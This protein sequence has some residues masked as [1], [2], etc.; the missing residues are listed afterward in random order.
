MFLFT[1][2]NRIIKAIGFIFLF[3][4]SVILLSDCEEES[5]RPRSYPRVNTLPVSNIT[6]NGATFNAEISSLGAEAITEHGFVWGVTINPTINND[7]ILLGPIETKGSYSAEVLTT[8]SKG[9]K[10]T[11]KP[12]V[13]TVDHIVYGAPVTFESLGSKA[14]EIYGFDPDSAGWMDT[15]KIVGK[16][17]SWVT[18]SNKVLFNKVECPTMI[19]TDTTLFVRINPNMSDYK[20]KIS[21]DLAG[22]IVI[23]DKKDFSLILPRI[24]GIS[25]SQA[26][27]GDT[28]VV[29]GQNF[30]NRYY[31][32]NISGTISGFNIKIIDKKRDS[33]LIVVP[34][35]LV[36]VLNPIKIKINNLNITASEQLTL[37]SPYI[38]GIKPK[39]GTWGTIVTLLGKFHPTASRNAIKIGGYSVT[40]LSNSKDSIKVAAPPYL[41]VRNNLVVN[42]S[43]PF[44]LVSPDTF[45]IAG[46]YIESITPLTGVSNSLI[47]I[48]GKYLKDYN[49][50]TS[51]KFGTQTATIAGRSDSQIQCYVPASLVNGPVNITVTVL[52]QTSVYK[53]PYIVDNPVITRVYPLNGTFN[54]EITIEGEKLLI[55][56]FNPDVY[57]SSSSG[58][59]FATM[60]SSSQNKI[61]VKVPSGIDS[62]PSKL[63][64]YYMSNSLAVYSSDKFTLSPPEITSVPSAVLIPGQDITINGN[65]F[66][67]GTTGNQVFWGKYPLTVTSSAT[68]QIVATV[69]AN[70]P[71]GF[72]KIS[73]I[74]GGYKREYPV[75]FESKSAWSEIPI[76]SSL[77]WNSKIW[78][79]GKGIAFTIGGLSY[80]IDPIGN[81]SS[82]NP[83]TKEFVNLGL[84]NE[85]VNTQGFATTLMNDTL[86]AVGFNYTLLI[87][88][89]RYDVGSNLWVYIGPCP[90]NRSNGVAFSLNG[91]V[92][93]GLG[94]IADN[95]I[96]EKYL[97]AFDQTTKKWILKKDIAL[98]SYKMPVAYFTYNNKGYVL[99]IDNIFCEY[100]PDTDVWTKLASFPGPGYTTYDR[101]SFI[102]NSKFYV[103]MGKSDYP[104]TQS[105]DFWYY[106][107]VT[108]VW[109][110]S[111][112]APTSGRYNSIGFVANNKVYIG[113]G[114][115]NTTP[116]RDFYEFDPNYPLK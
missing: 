33:L 9:I 55:T 58:E 41:S 2:I 114:L 45:K 99:F 75:L 19:S 110:K 22:N 91:K 35:E 48:K 30:T 105:N 101:T 83:V 17:F 89:Y 100:N 65:N 116:L 102:L 1:E 111:F 81:M 94:Y 66:S 69:P 106:D 84:H 54:D 47:T 82:F 61:I 36:T 15:V 24:T 113:F 103:G 32:N 8:L 21:V 12:Y 112:S 13:Q 39:E 38:S 20:S 72:N 104:Y 85:F 40:I 27:W 42:I 93:F 34:D 88:F 52:S 11:V 4:L 10:Y 37:Q 57:F 53:D 76:P 46:P 62:I 109:T 80:M 90:T 3:I 95:Y 67:P 14:P 68:N 31:T 108:N 50:N 51:V 79:N 49:G 18:T 71:S 5:A 44:T 74:V 92:Y 97:W 7:N 63:R 56:P 64:I 96:V 98:Y 16:N 87:G 70:V 23:Y 26:R 86:Y 73:I 29:F 28:I 107:P 25:P 59:R 77:V 6:E 43:T 115:N 60:V 78:T